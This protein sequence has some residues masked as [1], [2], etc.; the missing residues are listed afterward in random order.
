MKTIVYPITVLY[1]SIVT[2]VSGVDIGSIATD[3]TNFVPGEVIGIET[4]TETYEPETGFVIVTGKAPNTGKPEQDRD[5]AINNARQRAVE[6]VLGVMI[7]S[8]VRTENE[9]IVQDTVVSKSYGYITDET[10]LNEGYE[11]QGYFY[12]VELSCNV[13]RRDIEAELDRLKKSVIVNVEETIQGEPTDKPIIEGMIRSALI[14]AGHKCLDEGYIEEA[15]VENNLL[16]ADEM[17]VDNLRDVGRKYLA[18]VIVFG[19]VDLTQGPDISGDIGY[20][21]TNPLEGLKTADAVVNIKAVDT[22]TGKIIAER[23]SKPQEFRG[24]GTNVERAFAQ[25]LTLV[26]KAYPDFL[27]Q[28]LKGI[29]PVEPHDFTL[30]ITNIRDFNQYTQ[31]QR[32]ISGTYGITR[33]EGSFENASGVFDLTYNGEPEDFGISLDNMVNPKLRISR[34]SGETIEC[35]VAGF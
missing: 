15:G 11:A 21:D 16:K 20:S 10:I 3:A 29:N 26:G 27:A 35:E 23:Q 34:F 17:T 33:C 31:L 6:R 2:A 22:T 7:D 8:R 5:A 14:N 18:Q 28:S 9:L 30:I 24:A 25:A 1:L 32:T 19:T 13:S 4:S 12:V